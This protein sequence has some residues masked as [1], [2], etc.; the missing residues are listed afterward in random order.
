MWAAVAAAVAVALLLPFLL[1]FY[2]VSREAGLNRSLQETAIYSAEWTDYLAAAG[3]IHFNTWSRPFFAE[4]AS[5]P[6]SPG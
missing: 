4:T 6:A 1:P 5:F 2:I 3:T